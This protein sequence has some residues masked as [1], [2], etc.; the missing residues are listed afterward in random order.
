MT[1]SEQPQSIARSASEIRYAP[2]GASGATVNEDEE[3]TIHVAVRWT[4]SYLGPIRLTGTT[5]PPRYD[6]GVLRIEI[7]GRAPVILD[8]PEGTW[9]EHG[10]EDGLWATW[11]LGVVEVPSTP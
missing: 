1:G 5:P 3:F 10:G 9:T 6:L 4:V 7:E 11:D 2:M 8:V